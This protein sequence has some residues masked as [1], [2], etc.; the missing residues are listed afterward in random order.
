[1]GGGCGVR[2]VGGGR[3]R[4]GFARLGEG[5]GHE[6]VHIRL[7]GPLLL[8]LVGAAGRSHRAAAEGVH[9]E[10]QEQEVQH[11][12]R[13]L[14]DL[15]VSCEINE[16]CERG[17]VLLVVGGG[18]PL[19]E[20]ESEAVRQPAL[21]PEL[22]G[23]AALLAALPGVAE[24]FPRERLAGQVLERGEQHLVVLGEHAHGVRAALV[25]PV[26]EAEHGPLH[27]RAQLRRERGGRGVEER[28]E[29]GGTEVGA[30]MAGIHER[31]EL[32]HPLLPHGLTAPGRRE[33]RDARRGH[34]DVHSGVR[35][36]GCH[37]VPA[38]NRPLKNPDRWGAEPSQ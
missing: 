4:T 35:S 2:G 1:M 33:V 31:D 26:R 5:P 25:H 3:G 30:V 12:L 13:P 37:G 22:P 17:R 36:G 38:R 21:Q 6:G 28:D 9:G 15:P 7:L 24:A 11:G 10:V 27:L 8:R 18:V 29:G 23:G 16:E 14:R 32:P 19:G 34:L 20:P